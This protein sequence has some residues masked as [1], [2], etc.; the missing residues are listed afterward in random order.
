MFPQQDEIATTVASDD[1]RPTCNQEIAG[2]RFLWLEITGRCNLECVHCYADSGPKGELYGSM[3]MADWLTVIDDAAAAGCRALQ[4]IGGEPTVHPHLDTFILHASALGFELIE[5][6]TNATA[7]TERRLDF[8]QANGVSVAASFY[9]SD[10]GLHETITKGPGSFAKTVSGIAG[11]VRKGLPVRV[12]LIQMAGINDHDRDATVDFLHGLGVTTIGEDRVRDVG[13]GAK[14]NVDSGSDAYYGS[15]CGQCWKGSLCVTPDGSTYP[16]VFSRGSCVGNVRQT[17]LADIVHSRSLHNTRSVMRQKAL[18]LTA[19]D[20]A[21][22][23]L[24]ASHNAATGPTE[25]LSPESAL[26]HCDPS[27]VMQRCDPQAILLTNPSEAVA[28]R[29]HPEGIQLRDLPG[30]VAQHCDP[31]RV[32]QHCDPQAILLRNP[33][34]AVAQRCHPEGIQLRELPGVAAQRCHPEGVMQRCDPQAILLRN[35][36]EAVAQRCHPEGVMQRYQ[37]QAIQFGNPPESI[38]PRRPLEGGQPRAASLLQQQR[39]R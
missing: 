11:A 19:P 38:R 37:P 35:P 25:W 13:R 39:N 7:L 4:F 23:E 32:M 8:F 17:R 21:I 30:V 12:G 28:Q 33:S 14:R 2:L 15:L 6:Y 10:A 1:H 22:F 5:V 34:E 16:C 3:S 36:S 27:R 9:S 26:Q 20:T 29:C 24:S 18:S 31:S